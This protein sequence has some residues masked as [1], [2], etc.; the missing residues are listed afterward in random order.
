MPKQKPTQEQINS[1]LEL[2][3]NGKLQEA[4]DAL[5]LLSKDY[6]DDALLFNIRGA[7]YAGLGQKDA[8]VESYKKA[9]LL[10]PDYA[11]AHYNLGGALQ[12]LV[13][14]MI[15]LRVMRVQ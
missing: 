1:V 8:A 14:W 15:R 3:T 5:D 13:N 6:P 7:C 10:K 2:F 11:K 9:V 12:E 4:L